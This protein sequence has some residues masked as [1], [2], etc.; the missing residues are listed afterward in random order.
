[1]I[2]SNSTLDYTTMKKSAGVNYTF[3]R[4]LQATVTHN[5]LLAL[6]LEETQPVQIRGV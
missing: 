1:M 2:F 3:L 4:R 6:G 5:A